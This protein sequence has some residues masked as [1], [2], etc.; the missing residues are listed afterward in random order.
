MGLRIE[1]KN[2]FSAPKY[3]VDFLEI[4]GRDGD[5]IA[6]NGRFPNVQVTYSVFLPAKTISELS[7]KITAVK[8]WLYS[9]LDSYHTLSDTYDTAFFRHAVYAGKLNIEDE[10][11]RIGVFTISFSCK[12]FR[13]DEAGTVYTTLSASGDVLL[14][15]YPFISRPIIRIEG[16]GKGTLT[17]QSEGSNATWNFTA[18]DG[19]VEADSEQMNF[20]K[21]TEPK[22]DTVS[23]NGFPLLY[24]GENAIFYSGG[25]T[26]VTVIP[27]WCCL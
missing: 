26:A 19:Y 23:G 10:M 7:Q 5:L 27:R 13:Y 1:S 15:P 24:P 14:N 17:I 12:P 21:D 3:D 20:Y 16:K 11:N 6:G 8:A 18:I 25:I 4:P 2:V 9:G 22:N